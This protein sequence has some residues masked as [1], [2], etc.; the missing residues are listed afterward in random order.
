MRGRPGFNVPISNLRGTTL[1]RLALEPVF[2]KW[3]R[4]GPVPGGFAVEHHGALD[5]VASD[6]LPDVA[7]VLLAARLSLEGDRSPLQ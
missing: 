4:I 6:H 5:A 7:A 1:H 3:L 2:R